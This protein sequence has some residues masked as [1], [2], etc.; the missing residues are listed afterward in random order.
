MTNEGRTKS[1]GLRLSLNE[2]LKLPCW[3]CG[4]LV[5]IQFSK[6][7]KPY[8]ICN[9]CGIQ[10]FVRYGKAEDLLRTKVKEYLEAKQ[11]GKR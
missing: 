5:S 1:D 10:T 7:D 3:L 9:N 6:K 2:M 8:I 4:K 11:S